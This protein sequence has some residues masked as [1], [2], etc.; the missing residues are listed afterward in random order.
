MSKTYNAADPKQ[1]KAKEDKAAR[2]RRQEW[3]D[4]HDL[5]EHPQFI[6]FMRRLFAMCHMF[7]VVFTGNSTTFFKDGMRNV[8]LYFLKELRDMVRNQEIAPEKLGQ[9]LIQQEERDE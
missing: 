1:V 2:A 3:Q 6:R 9:L 5:L 8:G 7:E 4:L